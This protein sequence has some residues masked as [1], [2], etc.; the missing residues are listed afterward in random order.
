SLKKNE[1]VDEVFVTPLIRTKQTAEILFPRA[2]QIIVPGLREMDF[3]D[4]ENRNYKDMENDP[5]YRAWV[6]AQCVPAC[7]NGEDMEGFAAR[8]AE[9]FAGLIKGFIAEGRERAVFVVHGG[10]IMSLNY[11]FLRPEVPYYEGTIKN[12]RGFSYTL[13]PG[14]EKQPFTLI[15]RRP[16]EGGDF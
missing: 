5:D 11:V 10:T 15:D 1:E 14:D 6:E 9:A 7:P 8:C 3:G 16:V 13:G 2:R 4:F 12:C